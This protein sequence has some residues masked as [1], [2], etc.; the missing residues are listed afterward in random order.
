MQLCRISLRLAII[1]I[2]VSMFVVRDR[3]VHNHLANC[4]LLARSCCSLNSASAFVSL[5]VCVC[6]YHQ[7]MR[8]F[9]KRQQRKLFDLVAVPLRAGAA[10]WLPLLTSCGRSLGIRLTLC[11][12][13]HSLKSFNKLTKVCHMHC[14]APH[15]LRTSGPFSILICGSSLSCSYRCS[16]VQLLLQLQLCS[17]YR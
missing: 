14:C 4:L 5:C 16:Q 12:R 11:S 17:I 7:F 1:I 10:S 9:H 15:K 3:D 6:C 8:S 2:M 13:S